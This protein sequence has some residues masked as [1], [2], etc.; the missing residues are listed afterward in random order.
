M[1]ARLPVLDDVAGRAGG[2]LSMIAG[3]REEMQAMVRGAV[4]EALRR[5]DQVRREEVEVLEERVAALEAAR[6]SPDRP[7]APE[8]PAAGADA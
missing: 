2:A 6:A 1:R 7:A 5:L 8:R 3:L 4:D